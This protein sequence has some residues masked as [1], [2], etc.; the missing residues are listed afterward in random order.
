MEKGIFTT[1]VVEFSLSRLGVKWVFSSQLYFTPPPPPSL[2][3]SSFCVGHMQTV[4]QFCLL[5]AEVCPERQLPPE[6]LVTVGIPSLL[7]IFLFSV[8]RKNFAHKNSSAIPLNYSCLRAA[9][10]SINHSIKRIQAELIPAGF[11][12]RKYNPLSPL[13]WPASGK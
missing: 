1:P 6:S 5:F 2:F 10:K 11:A 3:S 7:N 4:G 13:R 8:N 12:E 9:V